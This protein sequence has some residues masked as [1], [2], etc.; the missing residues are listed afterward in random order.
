VTPVLVVDDSL[1]VRMDLEEAFAGA[2]FEPTLCPDLACARETL[3]RRRFGLVVLDVLLPDGDGLE[4]LAEL[5]H[6][7]EHAGTPVVLLSTEAEVQHRVR[8]LQTGADEYVGKPYDAAYVVARGRELV[9][10]R[11]P[12]AQGGAARG[13]VLVV[14][15]SLTAREALRADLERAGLEVVTAASGEEGLR[16]AADRR[17]SAVVVDGQMDGMDGAA[18][19]RQ[20]R[21]DAALR[22]TPCVL[23]TATGALGEL[24]ALE[25]GAD[26]YLRKEDGHAVVLARLQA[27]LRA[28]SP[29]EALAPGLLAPKRLLAVGAPADEGAPLAALGARLRQDGHE[30]VAARSADDAL[31]LLAVDRVDAILVD[32]RAA[33]GLAFEACRRVRADPR[34]RDLP[35]LVVGAAD[36]H[37]ATRAAV[38]AGADDYV[39][40][41][42]GVEVARARVRAQ[43]RRKAF[44][45][46][47]RA[48]EAYTRSAAIL[49]TIAD[50]FFAVN[51]RWRFVYVNH[52]FEAAVGARRTALLGET[53]WSC[54]PWL[55][56][57]TP[58]EALAGAAESRAPATFEVQA[59]GERWYEARVFPHGEGLTAYLRDVGERRRAQEVQAHFL[60]IVGHDLRTPLTAVAASVGLVLRDEALPERHRRALQRV[61]AASSRMTRLINDLLDYSRARLGEGVPIAPRP[62]H[63][64]AVCQEVLEELRAVYPGRSIAYRHEGDGLGLWDPDRIQQVLLNLLTN[65]LRHGPEDADVTLEWRGTPEEK[66]IGVNNAGPPIDP[67]LRERIFR[68]FTRGDA[69]GNTWGGVGLGLYI[70]EQIVAAHGGEVSLRSDEQEGTTFTIRLPA[71]TGDQRASVTAT[72]S[73]TSGA[74][75]R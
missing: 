34:W 28:S 74:F 11:G 57:G 59:P 49:E 51:R 7:P 15:D 13:P 2:G 24:G 25:A 66:V 71:T 8:G 9:R 70:V 52:A 33:P 18:F 31:E 55:A 21:A 64:D 12:P 26:A 61:A 22:T 32:G 65:A 23:L 53:L 27:L 48:R 75:D 54:C 29:A 14:D 69:A 62:S 1:T 63:L 5:K 6:A 39:P 36:E 58:A 19:V 73:V 50:A 60:G 41:A 4:L 42:A 37:D 16:V 17:P 30:V 47:N 40:D 44:E 43:L 10:R 56:Q 67:A 46:E 45:D 20:L 38:E 35:V 3:A 68:P 72:P